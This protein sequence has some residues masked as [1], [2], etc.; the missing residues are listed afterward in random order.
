VYG[1]PLC[2]NSYA[3][4]RGEADTPHYYF[5]MKSKDEIQNGTEFIVNFWRKRWLL[6]RITNPDFSFAKVSNHNRM[7][8]IPLYC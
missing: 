6:P 7:A 1:L 4:L 2:S 3:F 5:P 8:F